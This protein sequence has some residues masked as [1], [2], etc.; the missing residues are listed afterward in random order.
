[1]AMTSA[2]TP[3]PWDDKIGPDK[4]ADIEKQK[5]SH[6]YYKVFTALSNIF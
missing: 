1:M 4:I 6:S 3:C 5:R 2:G